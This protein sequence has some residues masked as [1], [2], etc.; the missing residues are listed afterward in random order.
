MLF[1]DLTNPWLAGRQTIIPSLGPSKTR[2][3]NGGGGST[4]YCDC[5]TQLSYAIVLFH[6]R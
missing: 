6:P 2:L 3:S 4:N 1:Y 5:F